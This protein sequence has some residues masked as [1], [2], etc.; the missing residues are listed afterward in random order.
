MN[1]I[2]INKETNKILLF[3]FFAFLSLNA[4][5]QDDRKP[6]TIQNKSISLK[7]AF[8]EIEQQTGYSIAYELSAVDVKRKISLS[9]ESQ[10][11]S[12]NLERHPIF[13]QNNRLPYHYH[14]VRQRTTEIHQGKNRETYPNSQRN[15]TG[16]Q[17]QC[18]H[19]VCY[20]KNYECRFFR[21]HNRQSGEISDKQCSCGTMQYTN[22]L[23]RI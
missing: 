15:C 16:F 8:A 18:T 13:V 17:N 12:A 20:C 10:S 19:R 2:T 14:S 23:C 7:E 11:V 21:Q 4:T 9:L 1:R 22:L 3:L 5:A 6:I